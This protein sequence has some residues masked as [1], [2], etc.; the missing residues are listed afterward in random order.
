MESFTRNTVKNFWS[1]VEKT[2]KCWFWRGASD[3]KPNGYGKLT[4]RH[5]AHTAHRVSWVIHNG[6][7]PKGEGYHG[8]CVLHKCDNRNCINPEHLF[9]GSQ[10]ENMRDAWDKGRGVNKYLIKKQT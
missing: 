3:G 8:V 10:Q 1:K 5:V 7:I 2:D 9:L 6:D 4:I